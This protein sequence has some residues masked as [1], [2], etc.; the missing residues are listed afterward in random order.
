MTGIEEQ[1][2]ALAETAGVRV[3][4]F[5]G[6]TDVGKTTTLLALANALCERNFRVGVVDADL[7]QSTIGPP[8]TIGLG[9]LREPVQHLGEAEVVGLYFVGAVTPAGHLLPTVCGTAAL[10]QKALRLGVE[11]LLI[12]TTGLV[13]GDI[14]RVLKQQKIELVAPDL[15]CCLQREGECEP[16]L[17][18][19][20]HG[21]R[22]Q[23]V[24]LTPQPGCR[25][26]GQEERRAYREQQFKRYFARAE[27]RELALP[28]LNLVGS[29]LFT[30]RAMEHRQQQELRA[31][32]GVPVLWGEIL[33]AQE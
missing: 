19:Y 12:D 9:L 17:R 5:L 26:R 25:V 22:P 31:T 27:P 28:E 30:G 23:I 18:A 4:L 15:I 8:T 1:V 21:R 29:P 11:K 3:I 16:I 2:L 20:R 32:T 7:G 6:R 24:R 33:S 10:V 13:S 14:G